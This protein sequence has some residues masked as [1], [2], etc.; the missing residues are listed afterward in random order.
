MYFYTVEMA[1]YFINE[2]RERIAYTDSGKGDVIVLLHG[3]LESS[4]VWEKTTGELSSSFRV[5]TVDLPGHGLSDK[6]S[7]CHSMEIMAERVKKLTD[8]LNIDQFFLVG[9]SMGGYVAL[10]FLESYSE[11]LAGYCLFHS[12]PFSDTPMA[13]QRRNREIRVVS[14]GRK[15]L[16]YPGNVEKMFSPLNL[17]RM[18]EERI[19]LN[20]IASATPDEGI[21]AVLKGMIARPSREE[22]LQKGLVPLLWV[23]GIHDQYIDYKAVV[24]KASLPDN[25]LLVTLFESGHLGFLEEPERSVNLLRDFAIRIFGEN[26]RA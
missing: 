4:R 23:L 15:R 10:A 11:K 19:R 20:E 24:S 12:H 1:M 17:E 3:Y 13:V 9:H 18:K 21:I 5:I 16:M 6:V 8:Y 22:L 2:K 7:D 14:A 26:S 25:A